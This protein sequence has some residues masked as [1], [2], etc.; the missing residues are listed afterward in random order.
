MENILTKIKTAIKGLEIFNKYTLVNTNNWKNINIF[1]NVIN[2][3]EK[4]KV[5]SGVLE[6]KVKA[7]NHR[8][9]Y[10]EEIDKA[11]NS[12]AETLEREYCKLKN[13]YKKKLIYR[14]ICLFCIVSNLLVDLFSFDSLRCLRITEF[15][16]NITFV[17]FWIFLALW[18]IYKIRE[19]RQDNVYA[20]C[21]KSAKSQ[22]QAIERKYK[23]ISSEIYNEID[24]LYLASLDPTHREVVLMRREQERQHKE[25]MQ[26]SQREQRR[27]EMLQEEQRRTR[28]AQ[29]K[30]LA[31]EE[32]RE[33][34]ANGH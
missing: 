16:L 14:A 31:I 29:E 33:K 21:V 25:R 23:N 11:L 5:I 6:C 26:E 34:R 3:A 10:M 13:I 7:E 8:Q 28:I 20:T 12:E 32:E 2:Y 9:T 19:K 1:N 27:L 18:I 22:A 17:A 4:H 24:D 15:F 30:L